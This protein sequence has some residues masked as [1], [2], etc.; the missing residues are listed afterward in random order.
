MPE[1]DHVFELVLAAKMPSSNRVPKVRS[2]HAVILFAT[3][4]QEIDHA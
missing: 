4:V 2:D 1:I 3:F